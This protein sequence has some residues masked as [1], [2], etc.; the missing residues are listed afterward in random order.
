VSEPARLV[1][2]LATGDETRED[3]LLE[4]ARLFGEPVRIEVV[5]FVWDPTVVAGLVAAKGAV[6]L[7]VDV[8]RPGATPADLEELRLAVAPVPVLR[9]VLARR[10]GVHAGLAS[11]EFVRYD[12]LSADGRMIRLDDREL[13]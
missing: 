12:Q 3:R 8:H 10:P 2:R 6:A 13:A 7:A 11:D 4:L 9:P 5:K 1:L